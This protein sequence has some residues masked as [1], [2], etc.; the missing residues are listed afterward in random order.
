MGLILTSCSPNPTPP[1][2]SEQ[3][4][5]YS[6]CDNPVDQQN[7]SDYT[8]IDLSTIVNNSVDLNRNEADQIIVE[9]PK[10]TILEEFGF[11]QM[12]ESQNQEIEAICPDSNQVIV[13]L[14]Q[15]G[16]LDDSVAGMRYRAEFTSHEEGSWQLLWLGRQQKCYPGRGNTDWSTE[17]C[18]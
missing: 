11:S 6:Q 17:L 18:V 7:R 12:Q 13:T 9:D 15:T 4:N 2:T 16:L 5:Q 1:D 10:T 8:A 3:T 14:T